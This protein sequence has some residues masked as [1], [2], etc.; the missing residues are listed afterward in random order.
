MHVQPDRFIL[1]VQAHELLNADPPHREGFTIFPVLL[2]PRSRDTTVLLIE[3][4]GNPDSQP[5]IDVPLFADKLRGSSTWD[6]NYVTTPQKHA[7]KS[8]EERVSA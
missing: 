4:G 5:D 3:A 6:W 8:H 7:C 2:H 1:R